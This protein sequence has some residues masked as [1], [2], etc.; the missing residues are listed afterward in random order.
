[1][2]GSGRGMEELEVKAGNFW[3]WFVEN[4]KALEIELE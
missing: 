4:R 3:R 1:V 2:Q